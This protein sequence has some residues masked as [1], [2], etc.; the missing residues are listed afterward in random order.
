MLHRLRIACLSLVMIAAVPVAATRVDNFVLL[1][2]QGDAHEL[3]YHQGAKSV[4]IMVQ[5]T[6]CDAHAAD[7]ARFQELAETQ[8]ETGHQFFLL[9][10]SLQDDR[11]RLA[12]WAR[13]TL[14]LR[15]SVSRLRSHC[16]NATSP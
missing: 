2:Q 6:D 14:P 8:A 11:S 3:Y 9:S 10:P 7:T 12:A 1:D 4:S 16:G 5:A 15:Q 13:D